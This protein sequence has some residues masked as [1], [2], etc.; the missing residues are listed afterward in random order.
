MARSVSLTS[1]RSEARFQSAPGSSGR[2]R[3]VSVI[4]VVRARP[5]RTGSPRKAGPVEFVLAT[6]IPADRLTSLRAGFDTATYER[7]T[8]AIR[9]GT[10]DWVVVVDRGDVVGWMVIEWNG[11]RTRPHHP[12]IT[13]VYVRDGRRREGI[14]TALVQEAERRASDRGAHEIGLSVNPSDNPD[15][16]RLYERLGYRHDGTPTYLDA[17]YGDYEDC[18]IDLVKRL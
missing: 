2:S 16:R 14:G 7:R 13:D 3:S 1:G 9:A 18:V 4:S 15:A 17:T 11:K 6:A 8:G 12:D 5:A 10:A